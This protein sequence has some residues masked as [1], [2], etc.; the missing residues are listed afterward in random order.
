MDD[1]EV[2]VVVNREVITAKTLRP[3]HSR[4]N[5][6]KYGGRAKA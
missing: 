2:D 6:H 1:S 4:V 5:G 3:I